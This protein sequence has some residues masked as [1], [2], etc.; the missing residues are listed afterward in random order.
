MVVLMIK[1]HNENVFGQLSK[2]NYSDLH[3]SK[4]KITLQK[5]THLILQAPL[6]SPEY[7]NWMEDL[8]YERRMMALKLDE[9]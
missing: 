4:K 9:F 1:Q 5:R 8:K 7:G 6:L 2:R 3:Y